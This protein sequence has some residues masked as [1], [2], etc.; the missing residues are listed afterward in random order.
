MSFA[1]LLPSALCPRISDLGF[2]AIS[3]SPFAI[4]HQPSAIQ[5]PMKTALSVLNELEHDGVIGRYAIGGAMGAAYY[6]EP[7]LTFDL[8]VFVMLPE[9]EG[10]LLSCRRFWIVTH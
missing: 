1:S 6:I 2:P 7:V 4:S 3:H 10:I 9:T 8:D 5:P